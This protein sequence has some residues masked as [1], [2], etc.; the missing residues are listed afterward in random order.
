MLS[1]AVIREGVVHYKRFRSP[2][3]FS[4]YK[5]LMEKIE[6]DEK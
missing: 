5:D 1:I 2:I 4:T 6:S 3:R